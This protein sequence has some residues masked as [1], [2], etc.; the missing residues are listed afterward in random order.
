[1]SKR[2]NLPKVD[3]RGPGNIL[4]AVLVSRWRSVAE[5][6]PLTETEVL[7]LELLHVD[8]PISTNMG[9]DASQKN[10]HLFYEKL[11]TRM[12]FRAIMILSTGDGRGNQ[13]QENRK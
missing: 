5:G 6:R 3:K 10:I 9:T 8:A 11:L 7:A 12:D 13:P 1:M 4:Q 2:R